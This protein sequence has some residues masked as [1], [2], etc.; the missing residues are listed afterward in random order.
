MR[1][2]QISDGTYAALWSKWRDGDDGE[3]GVI[4]RLL[5]LSSDRAPPKAK[6][7]KVGYRDNRYGVEFPEGFGI[8]RT[9]KGQ[10]RKA[11]A[12]DGGW[13]ADNNRFASSLNMLSKHIGAPTENA[14]LG[15]QY[16]D[17]ERVRPIADLRD[18]AKVRRRSA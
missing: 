2:I 3:E 8:F 12:Q 11:V 13:M 18:P 6:T 16:R 14:W 1:A 7:G 15:W 4:R 5:G 10:I 9:F 17:G